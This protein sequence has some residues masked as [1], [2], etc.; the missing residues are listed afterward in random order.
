MGGRFMELAKSVNGTGTIAEKWIEALAALTRREDL[1]YLTM[2]TWCNVLATR[3]LLH[4]KQTWC[5]DCYE[6]WRINGQNIYQPLLWSLSVVTACVHHRRRLSKHCHYCKRQHNPLTAR[7]VPGYCPTCKKWLGIST[8][9]SIDEKLSVEEY[10]WQCWV[11]KNVGEMLA[12]AS[13]LPASPARRVVASSLNQCIEQTTKG[14][15][16]AFAEMVNIPR[17]TVAKWHAGNQAPVLGALLRI[18]FEVGVS[19]LDFLTSERFPVCSLNTSQSKV[20]S[21][22]VKDR[23]GKKPQRREIPI[24]EAKNIRRILKKALKS[25]PPRCLKETVRGTE[26]NPNSIQYRFPDLCAA[27]ITRHDDYEKAVRLELGKRMSHELE[28][29]ATGV[30]SPHS[31]AEFARRHNWSLKILQHRFPKKCRA[32]TRR[33]AEERSKRWFTLRQ[34]L[35]GALVED[36][37]PSVDEF[38]RRHNLHTG[39]LYRRFRDLCHKLSKRHASPGSLLNS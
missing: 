37:P 28:A 19:P 11:T 26:R 18:C 16:N 31:L 25:N 8:I 32:L 23:Q 5:P 2:R 3:N 4:P 14:C 7:A 33:C 30:E 39:I 22:V 17:P 1:R 15:T 21:Q 36:P 10:K 35:E 9:S 24:Y 27:I 34:A 29:A 13:R 12:T 20:P 6:E 38:A